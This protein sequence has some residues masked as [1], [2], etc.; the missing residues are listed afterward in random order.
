MPRVRLSDRPYTFEEACKIGIGRF[1]LEYIPAWYA[2]SARRRGE[3]EKYFAPQ[4]KSDRE[5][6]DNTVFRGEPGHYGGDRNYHSINFTFPLGTYLDKPYQLPGAKRE[7]I[8]LIDT[9]KKGRVRL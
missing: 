7:R 2:T 4:F 9:P 3:V 8:R 1:T 5:W 6:Y